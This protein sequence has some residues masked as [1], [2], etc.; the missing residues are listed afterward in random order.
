MHNMVAHTHTHTHT[1]MLKERP[2]WW[3]RKSGRR[4]HIESTHK[5]VTYLLTHLHYWLHV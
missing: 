1:H 2:G 4:V 3:N 5:S